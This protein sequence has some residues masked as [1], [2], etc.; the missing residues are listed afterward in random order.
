MQEN[1]PPRPWPSWRRA[2]PQA[3]SPIGR[4]SFMAAMASAAAAAGRFAAM[5]G[6][7]HL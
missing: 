1:S 7:A 2:R 4:C 3:G 5:R 6:S